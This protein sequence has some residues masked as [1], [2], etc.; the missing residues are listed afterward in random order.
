MFRQ[1]TFDSAFRPLEIFMNLLIAGALD[2]KTA[3]ITTAFIP[4]HSRGLH[5]IAQGPGRTQHNPT[6]RTKVL[7]V[8]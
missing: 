4:Q 7:K 1:K 8:L 3:L 2:N 6:P 5:S